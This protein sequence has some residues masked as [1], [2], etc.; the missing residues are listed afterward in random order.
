MELWKMK[1]PTI[2]GK[3]IILDSLRMILSKNNYNAFFILVMFTRSDLQKTQYHG[4]THEGRTRIWINS[5]IW[6]NMNDKLELFMFGSI[7]DFMHKHTISWSVST[8]ST[9]KN[10]VT[11]KSKRVK[12]EGIQR[13]WIQFW[14]VNQINGFLHSRTLGLPVMF[15]WGWRSRFSKHFTLG[16]LEA[17]IIFTTYFLEICTLCIALDF[18]WLVSFGGIT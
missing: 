9:V 1:Y 2:I 13:F 16:P 15:W 4:V 18:K 12:K 10:Y 8:A 17:S 3:V 11:R 6:I 14:H 7:N 5:R